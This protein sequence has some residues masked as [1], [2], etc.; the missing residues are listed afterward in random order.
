MAEGGAAEIRG[1]LTMARLYQNVGTKVKVCFFCDVKNARLVHVY[2]GE[3]LTHREPLV[4]FAD[5][6]R[7]IHLAEP[8]MPPGHNTEQKGERCG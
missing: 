7:F 4:C 6:E 5:I 8:M 3:C 1:N 2:D